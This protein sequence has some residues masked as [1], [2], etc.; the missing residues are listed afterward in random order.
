MAY[1]SQQE[2]STKS[3]ISKKVKKPDLA[4]SHLI[5]QFTRYFE[6]KERKVEAEYKKGLCNGF[7]FLAQYYASLGQEDNF[8]E[9][10]SM[11]STW[12]GRQESLQ[13]KKVFLDQ[14]LSLE[15]LFEQWANDLIWFQSSYVHLAAFPDSNVQQNRI[16][17]F[18]CIKN[19]NDVR[20][21]AMLQANI[22]L[23]AYRDE[24]EELLEIWSACPSTIL[25]F[26]GGWHTTSARVLENGTFF[27]FDA[28]FSERMEVLNSPKEL[29]ALIQKTQFQRWKKGPMP[30]QLMAYQY[31]LPGEEP[32]RLNKVK[33]RKKSPN[34]F[35]PFHM[36]I[37]TSDLE[38]LEVLV[39]QKTGDPNVA[40]KHGL[41]PLN[42]AILMENTKAVEIL[43]QHPDI[44]LEAGRESAIKCAVKNLY[45][46]ITV[47]LINRG[48][49]LFVT[50]PERYNIDDI[51]Q[52]KIGPMAIFDTPAF[53]ISGMKSSREL[54]YI[55]E[56][57][58]CV[59]ELVELQDVYG[60][61]LLHLA[62]TLQNCEL[63]DILLHLGADPDHKNNEGQTAAE[64]LSISGVK[65][66]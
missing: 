36:A 48:I 54:A 51:S 6:L 59:H 1:A 47:M 56:L 50:H 15:E 40:E 35:T 42:L 61:T 57:V 53:I 18:E 26:G 58:K 5:D 44:N 49:D 33:S 22:Y 11:I 29:A 37:W 39:H 52:G 20:K 38:T 7:A 9:A 16:D 46:D 14:S 3:A 24:L 10:L 66:P 34:G 4:Q 63:M 28:N 32:R 21:I 23:D 43:L 25:E 31:V 19:K 2:V 41:T 55:Q 27:Y 13:K 64:L 62:A 30:L 65:G 8:F 60:N 45:L 12:D 17:Q